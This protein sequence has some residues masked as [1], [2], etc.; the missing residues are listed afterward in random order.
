MTNYKTMDLLQ[1]LQKTRF[2]CLE[3]AIKYDE[4]ISDFSFAGMYLNE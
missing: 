1:V 2:R 3:E 4:N